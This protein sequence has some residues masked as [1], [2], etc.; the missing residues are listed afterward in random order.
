MS[1][2]VVPRRRAFGESLQ[3]AIA[4]VIAV[5]TGF[6]ST[7]TLVLAALVH[8]GASHDE[9]SSG[10][11]MVCL[12]AGLASIAMPLVLRRPVSFSW[13]TPG[14]AALL[15]AGAPGGG[16]SDAVGAFI[17]AGVL[18]FLAGAWPPLER[19]VLAIPRPIASAMLA[20]ILLP[21]CLQP[22]VA[23]VKFPWVVG[24]MLVVWLVLLRFAA[25]WAV[26]AAMLIAIT[27]IVVL[28][29]PNAFTGL[30]LAP[31]IVW[32]W[33]TWD[34]GVLVGLA[35]PLFIVTMAGQNLPGFAV[36]HTFDYP[37]TV[38]PALM[39]SGLGSVLGAFGGGHAINLAALSA[40]LMA[41]PEA[42]PDRDR[43]WI[44]SLTNGVGYIVFGA[45]T[46]VMAALV[47][48]APPELI[49]AAA[50]LG[51]L[52]ALMVA[53]TGAVSDERSRLAAVVTLAVTVSGIMIAGVGSALWGLA[54][55][56]LTH[57]ALMRR[58]AQVAV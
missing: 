58:P 2:N 28:A 20:G 3:P 6:S 17:V 7:F 43:R 21:I 46:G 38:R 44:A 47:A 50:G 45:S 34:V 53:L 57:V 56:L 16:F 18:T 12:M 11:L 36:L 13:S 8:L 41:G 10:L 32:V 29:G 19:A 23:A 26:P 55:G 9:A 42:G 49:T 35:V 22:A 51:M 5:M 14:A 15:A 4:G 48:V 39:V 24:P 40:A 30:E 33:P 27:G 52:G 1:S 31:R 37:P 54:A 25:R